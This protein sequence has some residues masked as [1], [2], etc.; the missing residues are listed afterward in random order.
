[1]KENVKS[2]YRFKKSPD[3]NPN[4]KPPRLQSQNA[5]NYHDSQK[6]VHYS[7]F[8]V[9]GIQDDQRKI[10]KKIQVAISSNEKK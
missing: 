1:M 2:N 6:Y 3:P 9:K 7:L 5:I 4:P 8:I 10:E